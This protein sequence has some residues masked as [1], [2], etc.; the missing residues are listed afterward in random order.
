ML[1]SRCKRRGRRNAWAACGWRRDFLAFAASARAVT[2]SAY[3]RMVSS[4]YV[5]SCF[6]F[7]EVALL[8]D[9]PA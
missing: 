4:G 8:Q 7:D 5:N 2:P 6:S 3:S 1:L 9:F